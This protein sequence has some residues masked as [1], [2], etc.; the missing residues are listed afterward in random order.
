[1]GD[2]GKRKKI[3]LMTREELI[4][5]NSKN[6]EWGTISTGTVILSDSIFFAGH[7]SFTTVLELFFVF[8]C[9]QIN[10]QIN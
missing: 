6:G 2:V 10:L 1:M 8:T 3:S 9:K 4:A 5:R 7:A